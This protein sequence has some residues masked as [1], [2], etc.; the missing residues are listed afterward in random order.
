MPEYTAQVDALGTLRILESMR[1]LNLNSK[2]YQASTSELYGKV[3]EIPQNE[4][5]PFRP[6]SPY[7]IAKLYSYWLIRNY[8]KL[9][10]YMPRMVF[11]L[12]MNHQE[13]VKIL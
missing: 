9:M 6:R 10:V 4:A 7:A 11:F 5:T 13:E 1:A 3:A 2:F 8:R 12:I